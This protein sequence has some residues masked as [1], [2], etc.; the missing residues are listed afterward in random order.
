MVVDLGA[1]TLDV[2]IVTLISDNAEDYIMKDGGTHGNRSLGG[3]DMD[4]AIIE[5]LKEDFRKYDHSYDMTK[6]MGA[7]GRLKYATELAKISLSNQMEAPITIQYDSGRKTWNTKLSR[8]KLEELVKDKVNDCRGSIREAL[9][10]SGYN[11]EDID[12]V[13]LV[14]GPMHMPIVRNMIIDEFKNNK[15]VVENLKK[16]DKERYVDPTQC[17]AIGAALSGETISDGKKSDPI[18]LTT[19]S[20]YG[21][22]LSD[23]IDIVIKQGTI[24][25]PGGAMGKSY[26]HSSSTESSIPIIEVQEDG[27]TSTATYQ[28]LGS[29]KM[30]LSSSEDPRVDVEF[31]MD[32]NKKLNVTLYHSTVGKIPYEKV[33]YGGK[34]ID[35]LEHALEMTE[36]L[37]NAANGL[38]SFI[39]RP[40]I[41]DKAIADLRNELQNVPSNG[42]E[43]SGRKKRELADAILGK[44]RALGKTYIAIK[45]VIGKEIGTPTQES[46]KKVPSLNEVIP[47]ARQLLNIAR[48]NGISSEALS[49]LDEELRR[50][51]NVARILGLMASV[52]RSLETAGVK[53]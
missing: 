33:N 52:Q 37:M 40:E 9:H 23:S 38:K 12:K 36:E 4:R 3:L 53:Y 35:I 32:E 45:E 39:S 1:G 31:K 30:F 42:N 21:M 5:Y 27:K 51:N 17:V 50:P 20:G 44:K 11:Q 25:R 8:N 47:V 16:F 46:E 6:D 24:Y 34:P 49:S 43:L 7:M 29:L 26:Y 41:V 15:N 18:I 48:N 22:M 28:D 2:T 13:L 19:P 10:R 14:G